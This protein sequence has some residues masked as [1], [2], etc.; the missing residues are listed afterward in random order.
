MEAAVARPAVAR[1]ARTG[2][3]YPWFRVPA[4]DHG[5][6]WVT[7]L[8]FASVFCHGRVKR[9]V[10][11]R[12]TDQRHTDWTHPFTAGDASRPP[13][14]AFFVGD[15]DGPGGTCDPTG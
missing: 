10:D 8:T 3:D 2:P 4:T 5:R 1:P 12:V 6:T 14:R 15:L 7:W 11:G 9:A 13:T